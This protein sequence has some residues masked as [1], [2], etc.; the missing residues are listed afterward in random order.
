M[1]DIILKI[2]LLRPC[3]VVEISSS[4]QSAPCQ[5][6]VVFK[7]TEI[8]ANGIVSHTGVFRGARFH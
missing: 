6:V 5:L 8:F 2:N 3:L 1:M 7:M 4:S